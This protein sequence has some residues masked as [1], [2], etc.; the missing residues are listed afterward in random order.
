MTTSWQQLWRRVGASQLAPPSTP[1][2]SPLAPLPQ[3]LWPSPAAYKPAW[4][5]AQ[6]GSQEALHGTLSTSTLPPPTPLFRK[7]G[8]GYKEL[9]ICLSN[10]LQSSW[11]CECSHGEGGGPRLLV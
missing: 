10:V 11:K 1:T 9:T 5:W 6:F 2:A 3:R 7:M 4:G 8:K